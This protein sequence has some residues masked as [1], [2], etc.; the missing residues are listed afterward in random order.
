MPQIGRAV[1]YKWSVPVFEVKT[2]GGVYSAVIERGVLARLRDYLP[3]GHGKLFVVSEQIVWTAHGKLLDGIADEILLLPGG[4]ENK[5]LAPLEVLAERMVD[6]AAD[7]TSL[8][9]AFGGG[10]V[11]DMAGFLAAIF[12]RGIPVVQVPTT[13]LA[14]VDASVGG[15]TG[16]NLTRGKNLIGSFHQPHAVLIDPSLLETLPEREYRAGLYE[17]IKCGVIASVSLFETLRDHREQVLAREPATV[18]RLITECVQIKAEVVS[19]DERESGRRRILNFGHT[20]GHAIEAET[21]YSRFLHGEAVALGMK[22][23]VY[24]ALSAGKIGA[25][26]G[27]SIL[28]M[29][30]QYGP[31]PSTEGISGERIFERL[32]S[33]KKTRQ[34]HV[35]FVLP[36]GIGATEV[37]TG[38]EPDTIR[39]A[40]K[41][42]LS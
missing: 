33:D 32:V 27:A 15:K 22:G 2:P 24:L 39:A 11:N 30:E 38:L 3:S 13:L 29:I 10:I 14:Q 35:H 31:V 41:Q 34:G 1:C 37:V 23:A 28:G 4:E 36:V 6:A 19:E 20:I 21:G 12:L 7:R 25:S 9:I 5:R 8:V 18:D 17:V 42:A 16:V 26:E 40:I